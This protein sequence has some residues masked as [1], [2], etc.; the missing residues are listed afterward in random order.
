M[1]SM[2]TLPYAERQDGPGDPEPLSN[3]P[4][5]FVFSAKDRDLEACNW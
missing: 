1:H 3:A 5:G 2:G 4:V